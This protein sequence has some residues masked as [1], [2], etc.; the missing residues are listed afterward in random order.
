MVKIVSTVTERMINTFQIMEQC[1]TNDTED[2]PL[3]NIATGSVAPQEIAADLQKAKEIG[4]NQFEKFV[5]KCINS[6]EEDFYK[7]VARNDLKTFASLE[8]N[9]KTMSKSKQKL[10]NVNADRQLFGRLLVISKDRDVDVEELFS[11]ELSSVLLSLFTFDGSMVKCN[12][13]MLSEG[14]K[15]GQET[16]ETLP[17]E[18]KPTTWIIDFMALI[19]MVL[20]ESSDAK[21]FGELSDLLLNLV[22]R[23][24]S[25][26]C[27]LMSVVCDRYGHKDSIKSEE[28]ARRR[29]SLMQEIQVRN[30]ITSIPKRR[31]RFLSNCKNKENLA[32][33]L[34]EDWCQ[35]AARRLR[36]A[37]V[38]QLAGG[39]RNGEK[40]VS[41]SQGRINYIE[42]LRSDHEEADSRM[43][44]HLK[45]AY[46]LNTVER[47]I[48]WGPDTNVA[49][50]GIHFAEKFELKEVYLRT[51]IKCKKR[52]I[53]IHRIVNQLSTTMCQFLPAVH[54]F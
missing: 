18:V 21:T 11:Y 36:A 49:V 13:S 6:N 20:T 14:L 43:F 48:I 9:S 37:H 2:M 52:F 10:L 34:F 50:L 30:R 8:K 12:K 54:A 24:S 40:T 45:D 47:Y 17:D 31:R 26:S 23:K 29:R 5:E 25:A 42:E 1:D 39:F 38:L 4:K 51:G 15:K 41:V 19:K 22:F 27:F 35:E 44:V 3:L 28:R 7:A 53:P 46:N 32:N 16:F 33:F